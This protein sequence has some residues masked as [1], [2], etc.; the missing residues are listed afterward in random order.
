[1]SQF[2]IH[3]DNIVECIRTFDY[4]VLAFSKDIKAI[5]G[6]QG[7]ITSPH[8]E[9]E[10][11]TGE[12]L[13]FTFLPGYGERRWNQ[14]ILSYIRNIGGRLREAADAII[15]RVS[16]DTETPLLAIEFCGALP[17]GNNAWQRHGRAFSFAHAGIP[18]FYLAELGGYE[19]TSERGK[20]AE[21][22][23]NP[24]VP[25]SFS[26]MTHYRR[27]TC[28]PVYEANS[29]ARSETLTNYKSVFGKG[30]FLQY[31][32]NTLLAEDTAD[33]E[34]I[35]K[36][37]CMSLVEQ[38]ASSKKRVGGLTQAQWREAYKVLTTKGKQLTE[39]LTEKAPIKWR[40]TAY[41]AALTPS[42][43]KLITFSS[44]QTLGLTSATL[45]LSFVPRQQRQ[46]FSR[47]LK[48]IYPNLS[49]RAEAWL[50]GSDKDLAI[51]WVMGFKPKGD[52]ARPDRGLPPLA[53]MLI[54]D[55][56]DLLTIIYGPAPISH[57]QKLVRAPA[58][59]AKENGLWEAAMGVSDAILLDSS[60]MLTNIPRCILKPTWESSFSPI[61]EVLKVNPAVL[62]SSEQDVDTALHVLLTSLGPDLIFEGMC[63]PPGGDWSGVSFVWTPH[64]E[65]HR[66]LTLPRVSA[67][68]SKRPDHIFGIFGLKQP[69]CLCVES[70]ERARAIEPNIGPRLIN[71]TKALLSSTPSISRKNAKEAWTLY[72]QPWTLQQAE[73]V[74]MGAYIASLPDPFANVPSGTNLDILWGFDFSASNAVCSAYVKAL[75]PIGVKVLN[76]II[77][78]SKGNPFVEFKFN[79]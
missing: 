28:L 64:G 73:Y 65:E 68:G 77:Q 62:T 60:T 14:D 72:S 37:K 27:S 2:Q 54:G 19:L 34:A 49:P 40:K 13:L 61:H 52:D 26:S 57:W 51:A 9:I 39:Y 44:Q 75:T 6:P 53:R 74:S 7:S 11:L 42:V 22:W 30:D 55:Q 70:K 17:A 16:K 3:G 79:Q 29:G 41:I 66:W 18:Y 21:R 69:V 45:P 1:M 46:K 8:Y 47:G 56:T 36:Q 48:S 35:L 10:V 50:A 31:L 15:T 43:K 32:R 12:R 25:F 4:V 23:P 24:A 71:Y 76:Y 63:N 59:L 20:K 58:Q 5:R 38:L 33:A 67:D 78:A